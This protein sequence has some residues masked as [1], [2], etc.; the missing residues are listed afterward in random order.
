MLEAQVS[1]IPSGTFLRGCFRAVR[2]N[3]LASAALEGGKA[4]AKDTGMNVIDVGKR[5][6]IDADKKLVE[7]VAK[8]LTTPESHF[9]LKFN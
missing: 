9:L 3:N 7:K 4:A 5:V 8:R 6:A 1:S 2:Q